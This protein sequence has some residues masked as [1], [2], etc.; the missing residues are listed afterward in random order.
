MKIATTMLGPLLLLMAACAT[1]SRY[2]P[3]LINIVENVTTYKGSSVLSLAAQCPKGEPLLG[4]GY[5]VDEGACPISTD[6]A[7]PTTAEAC[8]PVKLVVFGSYPEQVRSTDPGKPGAVN[9]WVTR[10]RP[11]GPGNGTLIV[12]AYCYARQ[13]KSPVVTTIET[14]SPDPTP[15]QSATALAACPSGSALTGGGFQTFHESL[16]ENAPHEDLSASFPTQD[17][18]VVNSQIQWQVDAQSLAAHAWDFKAYAVC[19]SGAL[20]QNSVQSQS[21]SM[22]ANFASGEI[23]AKCPGNAFTTNVGYILDPTFPNLAHPVSSA[24]VL[25]DFDEAHVTFDSQSTMLKPK[26]LASCTEPVP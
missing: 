13:G 14:A 16:P 26:A 12:V 9:Q 3:A 17:S 10:V 23:V 8:P 21:F 1:P 4:G 6:P 20:A 25:G 11:L 18:S 24:I 2:K 7:H 22:I 15:S 19:A 5:H